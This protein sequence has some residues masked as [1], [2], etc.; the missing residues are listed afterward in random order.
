LVSALQELNGSQEIINILNEA[1][2]AGQKLELTHFFLAILEILRNDTESAP[3][4]FRFAPGF[5][6]AERPVAKTTGLFVL[7][8]VIGSMIYVSTMD[9]YESAEKKPG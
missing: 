3:S 5:P 6:F 4:T 8:A 9:P 1:E 7:L 2:M